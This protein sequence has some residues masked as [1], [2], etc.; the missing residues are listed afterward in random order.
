MISFMVRSHI[1]V[2]QSV[3]QFHHISVSE[4]VNQ[5]QTSIMASTN[6]V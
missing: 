4:S 6:R 3:S 2:S 5:K 1:S